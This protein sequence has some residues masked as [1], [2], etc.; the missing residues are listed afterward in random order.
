MA[1]EIWAHLRFPLSLRALLCHSPQPHL[2]TAFL[3]TGS[4]RGLRVFSSLSKVARMKPLVVY[5]CCLSASSCSFNSTGSWTT[6][7]TSFDMIATPCGQGTNKAWNFCTCCALLASCYR[8]EI[9]DTFPVFPQHFTKEG[10]KLSF[11]PRSCTEWCA[12]RGRCYESWREG[13]CMV[14]RIGERVGANFETRSAK[15]NG[16]NLQVSQEDPACG[17][18]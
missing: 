17:L 7:R 9:A 6:M 4:R 2:F 1:C 18:P 14:M 5:P 3:T 16:E 13:M 11:M 12:S 10:Q 15:D 8:C